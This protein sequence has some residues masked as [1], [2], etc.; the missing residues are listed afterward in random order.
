[1]PAV[2]AMA[3]LAVALI[4]AGCGSSSTSTSTAS[5]AAAAAS[6]SSAASTASNVAASGAVV[7]V[8]HGSKG[9][10]LT[11]GSGRALYLWVADSKDKSNCSGACA[12]AWPPLTTKGTP[13]GSGG[14]TSAKLTT[15]TRSDGSKQVVYN[16]HPLYY[17]AG[18]T[19]AGTTTG[20]GNDGFGAKWWL[21]TPAGAA[22]TAGGTSSSGAGSAG[23]AGSSS[24]SSGG[25]G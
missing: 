12:Q 13:T 16:G 20:Q 15:I 19:G 6:T 5:S 17:F 23:S 11:D 10:Y 2:V 14:V 9:M 24:S 3:V 21:V 18:D 22:I 1:M 8:T 7:K 4:A 25:W